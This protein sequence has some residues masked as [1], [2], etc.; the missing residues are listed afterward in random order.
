[1]KASEN[2]SLGK[3]STCIKFL[4][5]LQ[6]VWFVAS[7]LLFLSCMSAVR[8]TSAQ[9]MSGLHVF[10]SSPCQVFL[11]TC[12]LVYARH[13][14]FALLEANLYKQKS[15]KFQCRV[16]LSPWFKSPWTFALSKCTNPIRTFLQRPCRPIHMYMHPV[17]L[18]IYFRVGH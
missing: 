12:A 3:Q 10:S 5:C 14:H 13:K 17:A 16:L 4:K 8:A 11:H 6:N 2:K 18:A 15:L 9:W 1:M 7:A